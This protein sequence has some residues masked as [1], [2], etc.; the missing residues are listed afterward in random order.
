VDLL[1]DLAGGDGDYLRQVQLEV[2]GVGQHPAHRAEYQRVHHEIPAG[3]R[4]GD[5][6]PGPPRAGAGEG[7][8]TGLRGR[9]M[10]AQLLPDTV[11]DVGVDEAVD[12]RRP[13]ASEYGADVLGG[14]GGWQV[15]DAHV[16]E[17]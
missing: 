8:L 15:R 16:G 10:C 6:P 4:P 1:A 2:G 11:H 14:R 17:R 7:V 5:E 3:D 12:D 13:V 9:Q